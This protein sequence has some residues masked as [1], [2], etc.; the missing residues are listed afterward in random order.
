MGNRIYYLRQARKILNNEAGQI[1]LLSSIYESEPWG[2][3]DPDNYL[4]QVISLKT[5]KSPQ[6][7]LESCLHIENI[8][9][10]KRIG[11]T[12]QPR[13]IDID[14]LFYSDLCLETESLII[15]HPRLHLRNFVL[16]P[17]MEILPDLVHPKLKMSVEELFKLCPDTLQVKKN[18]ST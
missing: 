11:N 17:L 6:Q 8:L 14:I 2:Y 4:N 3:K 13:P 18:P 7:L 9:G 5:A 15:P 16:G 1:V 10:R 12:Y